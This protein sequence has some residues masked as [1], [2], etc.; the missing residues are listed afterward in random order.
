MKVTNYALNGSVENTVYLVKEA[1]GLKP[2]FSAL[3]K[4][5]L[6]KY[7]Q[8]YFH[9]K[10]SEEGDEEDEDVISSIASLLLYLPPDSLELNR[11]IKKFTEKSFEKVERLIELHRLYFEKVNCVETELEMDEEEE[12]LMKLEAGLFTLQFIDFILI[13][14]SSPVSL[15]HSQ[16]S[17]HVVSLLFQHSIPS[18]QIRQTMQSFLLK[19]AQDEQ[20]EGEGGKKDS[21]IGLPKQLIQNYTDLFLSKLEQKEKESQ[22]EENQN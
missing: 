13:F 5:N 19:Y 3:M 11:T 20:G 16:L 17:S 18:F 2:L 21:P 9:K 12:Y 6:G 14:I 7:F 8:K 1:E 22:T 4:K 10:E 15:F